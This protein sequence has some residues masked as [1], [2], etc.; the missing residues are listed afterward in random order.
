MKFMQQGLRLIGAFSEKTFSIASVSLPHLFVL[1]T[2]KEL[3][4]Y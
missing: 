2:K 1:T 4:L 3:K